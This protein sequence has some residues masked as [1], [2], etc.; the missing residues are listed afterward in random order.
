[1]ID[2]PL[3]CEIR[4]LRSQGL[5]PAQVARQTGLDARTV[6]RWFDSPFEGA[7]G[8][9]R[10]ASKL[11]PFK[12][13]VRAL[14]REHP[15]TAQQVFQTLRFE[16]YRGGYTLVKD[17]VRQLRPPKKEAF[18]QLEFEPG[19]CAQVDWGTF[20]TIPVEGSWR[21][22]SFLVM[23]LAHSRMLHVHFTLAETMEHFLE[24]HLRAF[25]SLRG[26]PRRVWVD[27][28]KVAVLKRPAHGAPELN[29]RYADFARHHG[30]EIVPCAVRR[31]QQK[32]RVE[33]AV[34]YVKKN[35]LAG[36]TFT[37]FAQVQPAAVE[38]MKG[39]ANVR[40][41]PRTGE[42][43]VDL[44]PKENLRPLCGPPYD[45]AVSVEARVSR[46]CRV[47]VDTNT[48]T[49]PHRLAGCRVLLKR[50][51]EELLIF[52]DNR[53]VAT[54]TRRYGRRMDIVNEDHI[55]PLL[56]E[57]RGAR[58][59]RNLVEFLK[60]G[61]EAARYYEALRHRRLHLSTHVRRILALA[62]THG[63]EPVARA[64][65]DALFYKAYDSQYILNILHQRSRPKTE[66]GALHLTRREDLLEVDLPEPDLGPYHL[67][68]LEEEEGKDAS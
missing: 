29:P 58:E 14:L 20:G 1:M 59:R 28:C 12:P 7:R 45:P 13:R 49:A 36:H 52:H 50:R 26:V 35:F 11:D 9:T 39:V 19:D 4:R 53:L 66:P 2:Y 55:S 30:F 34:G 60:L 64:L 47:T 5:N 61:P 65:R 38:W 56:E 57:R 44:W 31:P 41:H 8:K 43:P 22:L 68:D 62:E 32:G 27:N 18:I 48:Y 17:F 25:E 15:F 21:R 51:A 67:D 37:D 16:G 40:K 24:A 10:T 63:P 46:T 3:W 6:R 42:R 54:H 23:V 33:N